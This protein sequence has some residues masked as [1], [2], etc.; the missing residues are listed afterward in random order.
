MKRL[1]DSGRMLVASCA[2]FSLVLAVPVSAQQSDSVQGAHQLEA[3][4]S[5]IAKHYVR[6]VGTESLVAAAARG[7]IA[8]LDPY[9]A[10]LNAADY[11]NFKA[12][13]AGAF[14]G[15]G[16]RLGYDSAQAAFRV[17]APYRN[18][19][20]LAAGL[21][22]DDIILAVDGQP[23]TG[24]GFFDV[25]DAISGAAGS[26]VALTVRRAGATSPLNFTIRRAVVDV[27][28]IRGLRRASAGGWDYMAG[29]GSDV[30]Y[31]RIEHFAATTAAEMDTALSALRRAGARALILDLREN[32]GG[33]LRTALE[34][35][36]FFLDGGRMLTL[37]TVDGDTV[38]DARPGVATAVPLAILVNQ[39]T[40]SAAEVLASSLQDNQRAVIVGE[41]TYGKGFG[42]VLFSL[43][44]GQG[45]LRLTTIRMERPSG[46]N[47][48]RH[49][50]SP[51]TALGGVWPD[52]GM[53]RAMSP[54]E[55]R[56]WLAVMSALDEG[57][58][59]ADGQGAL[60][61]PA[62]DPVLDRALAVLR[63]R[64]RS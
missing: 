40:A 14:S 29:A 50:A 56:S 63:R 34:T 42:Q 45:A 22:A 17:V 58:P 26:T 3:L 28:T 55:Y 9:S 30:G 8:S 36:D 25:L 11:A 60:P 27:P 59:F 19:P 16:I 37:H 18:S 41:R 15:I 33:L 12:T 4:L 52:S 38:Y 47:L 49:M 13:L 64:I 20:A 53:T 44:D 62:V 35:A 43:A 5:L 61:S 2:A 7:M 23:V 48:D 1:I 31:I 10:W 51:D 57:I 54:S 24:R 46:R 6:P 21:R 39:R 32:A